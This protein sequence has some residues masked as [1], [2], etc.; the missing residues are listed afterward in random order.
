MRLL[1]LPLLC[2]TLLACG[3]KDDDDNNADDTGTQSHSDDTGQQQSDDTGSSGDDTGGNG[4]TGATAD[5]AELSDGECPDMDSNNISTGKAMI[6]CS[7]LSS[8]SVST[9]RIRA[10]LSDATA[11]TD[12][13]SSGKAS[14][15]QPLSW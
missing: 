11:A 7:S 8:I 15:S 9:H 12:V 2:G 14:R 1:L 6:A 10:T 3:N 13:P 4:A 5:L